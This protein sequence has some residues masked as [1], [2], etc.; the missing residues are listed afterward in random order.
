MGW[1]GDGTTAAAATACR[2]TAL[3]KRLGPHSDG[4]LTY[5]RPPPSP[6][7]T[8][9]TTGEAAQAPVGVQFLRLASGAACATA[10]SAKAA[11]TMLRTSMVVL[12]IFGLLRNGALP[13]TALV[14]SLSQRLWS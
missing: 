8:V 14:H 12:V 10:P 5:P 2:R 11:T 9:V 7:H 6:A 13:F 4:Q 1:G 3:G